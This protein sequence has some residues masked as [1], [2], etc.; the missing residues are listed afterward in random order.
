MLYIAYILYSYTVTTLFRIIMCAVYTSYMLIHCHHIVRL[1]IIHIIYCMCIIC[2]VY[3]SYNPIHCHN[4]ASYYICIICAVYTSYTPIHCHHIV[5]YYNVCCIYILYSYTV[6][7]LFRI[8]SVS[9]VLRVKVDEI[10]LPTNNLEIPKL[11]FKG[12]HTV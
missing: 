4:I 5:S 12:H 9:F 11:I 8:I 1:Q 10:C 6:T 3:T 2:D 7:T